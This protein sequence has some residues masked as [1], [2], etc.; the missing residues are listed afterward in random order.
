MSLWTFSIVVVLLFIN[1]FYVAAEFAAVS[2]RETRVALLAATG[3]RLAQGLL[4]ILRNPMTLDRYIACCQIGITASSLVLG[5]FGPTVAV[6]LGSALAAY[7]GLDPLGAYTL[8]A[9]LTLVTLTALQV[10]LGEL[11]PKTLALQYPL[12]T[13]LFTYLPMRW[14]LRLYAPFID[15]AIRAIRSTWGI[16]TTS[17]EP[18]TSGTYSPRCI[19][20]AGSPAT[21]YGR[22][23]TCRRRQPSTRSGS[24]GAGA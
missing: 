8:S 9:A 1:A 18:G 6:A 17:S 13:A 14:S 11:I 2:V 19:G 22:P 12:P 20:A 24:H 16:T 4:P 10:V 15:R 3:H 5:A 7:A 21:W 23:S